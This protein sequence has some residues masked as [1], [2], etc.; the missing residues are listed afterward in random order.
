MPEAAA[1]IV[2]RWMEQGKDVVY[3]FAP[4]QNPIVVQPGEEYVTADE[5]ILR[6]EQGV[7][8]HA[9]GFLSSPTCA[10]RFQHKDFDS[11][12]NYRIDTTL[13]SGEH[14]PNG[15]LW[16]KGP[17][18]LPGFYSIVL[19]VPFTWQDWAR[20]SFINLDTNPITILRSLYLVAMVRK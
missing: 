12:N 7:L 16:A 9:S 3:R 6:C 18:E 11:G 1:L 8:W 5:S 2:D 13:L 14:S 19:M 20:V 10:I 15:A 17:P 4:V